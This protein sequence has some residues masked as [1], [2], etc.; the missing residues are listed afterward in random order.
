[1][2]AAVMSSGQLAV[3]EKQAGQF[4]FV[5]TIPGNSMLVYL[6]GISSFDVKWTAGSGES[7]GGGLVGAHH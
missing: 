6:P 3:S 1:M 4:A 2:S 7:Q 5:V